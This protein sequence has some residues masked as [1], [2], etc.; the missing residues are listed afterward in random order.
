MG[1]TLLCNNLFVCT[2]NLHNVDSHLCVV[3]CAFAFSITPCALIITSIA[4]ARRTV[5]GT[6]YVVLAWRITALKVPNCRL[7]YAA[8]TGKTKP[9]SLYRPILHV[10]DRPPCVIICNIEHPHPLISVKIYNFYGENGLS[11]AFACEIQYFI[12]S[13]QAENN[14]SV[15]V[16]HENPEKLVLLACIT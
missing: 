15:Q 5:H 7:A 16:W 14:Q 3:I 9:H 4:P 10:G 1:Q 8:S 6:E 11:S 2:L 13:L 12:V